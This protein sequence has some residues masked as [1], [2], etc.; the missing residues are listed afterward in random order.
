VALLRIDVLTLFPEMVDGPLSASIVGRARTTGALDLHIHDIRTWTDDVHRTA[1]DTPYGGGAGMVMKAD[2][3]VRGVEA[4]V[5]G[6]EANVA[7]PGCKPVV[8]I[9]SAAGVSF[10]QPLAVTWSR[11]PHLVLICGHYEG[12]DDRVRSFLGA[13]EL[14]IG[15]YVLTG[16]E[17]AAAVVIDVVTRLLPG[18]IRSDSIEHES[19]DPGTGGLLE[20][21]QFTR[22]ATYRGLTVPDVLLSGNHAVIEAWRRDQAIRKTAENRPDLLAEAKLTDREWA[23]INEATDRPDVD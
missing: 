1:D 7:E 23:Q 9:L 21:P 15:D 18:V 13:I 14:S 17:L 10:G 16:G 2:P 19:H 22:P 3:I 12:I 6:V 4:I 11:V 8:V 20:H 5:R